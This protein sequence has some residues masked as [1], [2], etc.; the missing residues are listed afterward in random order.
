ME[1]LAS[2]PA[3]LRLRGQLITPKDP[4]YDTARRVLNAMIDKRPALIARCADEAD[5]VTAVNYARE[6]GMLLAVRG[7]AH[8][9]AGLGTC[10]DGLVIDLS[11]L[12]N[13]R[14]DPADNTVRVQGGC[15]LGDM[16]AATH[17]HGRAVPCGINATTG[18]GGL[19]LGGGLG[20][21]TRHYGLTID[22]LLEVRMVLA[23][24]QQV[25]ASA[26]EHPDLFWAIRGGGGNFGVVTEFRFQTHPVSTVYA[27]PM[28]WELS[29]T[30]EVMQWY[31]TFIRTAPDDIN[32]FFA[33]LMVPPGEPFPE[34]LHGKRMCGI[35]WC[36]TGDLAK[37]EAVFAPIR[38][39]KTP[40]LDLVG[41]L[42]LPVLQTMFDGLFGPGMQWYWK[43]D[44][45]NH[46]SDEVID[47][48]LK[49][50]EQL[51]SIFSGMHL[52]PIN[53]AASR[54]G[55]TDTAWNYR[56]AT[57]AM[58]MA[59]VDPDPARKDELRDWSRAYW[60]ALHPFSAG[61]GYV[62][63][64]MEEGDDRVRAT[65]GDNYA[66]LAQIKA[67]YDPENLFRVNQNIPPA[68]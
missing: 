25:T 27:G 43:A 46:L 30:K 4:D 57:W 12:R 5:V 44:F 67:R 24:G 21:L 59:G 17:V 56:H 37:A 65:Y 55:K 68:R 47:L 53:G 18:I 54:V 15:L 42:P 34:P 38:A 35:V 64:M 31:E 63:F 45:F 2:S 7:G 32:G 33:F 13:V 62:N 60:E 29:E 9:G 20:Y 36:Y 51:P 58:V 16:D 49:F 50:G 41:E 19:T 26:T 61:G 22:N 23:D 1:T 40:T 3:S 66:R 48:H 14:F 52:Y 10:D 6:Q 39:F 8:N 28:L 11:M